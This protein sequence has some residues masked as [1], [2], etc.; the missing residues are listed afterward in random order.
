MVRPK[1]IVVALLTFAVATFAVDCG[2]TITAEEAA[3]CCKNMN[4]PSQGQSSE[5]CCKIMPSLHAPF[6]Q[7]SVHEISIPSVAVATVPVISDPPAISSFLVPQEQSH[8]PPILAPPSLTP[9]R[10]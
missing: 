10:V 3:L 8:A 5:K 1:I 4:C 7:T 9:I 6:V 2:A